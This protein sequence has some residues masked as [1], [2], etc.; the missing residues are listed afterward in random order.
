MLLCLVPGDSKLQCTAVQRRPSAAA[1][2]QLGVG[3]GEVGAGQHDI[4]QFEVAV[5]HHRVGA[6]QVVQGQGDVQAP[7]QRVGVAAGAGPGAGGQ[8]GGAGGV[9]M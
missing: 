1:A 2:D 3:G 5:D 6:V 8:R 4:L 7:A 9:C